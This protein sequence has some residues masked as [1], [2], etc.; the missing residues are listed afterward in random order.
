MKHSA[1][2]M[3][4]PYRKERKNDQFEKQ[5]KTTSNTFCKRV[6]TDRYC[7]TA[8]QRRVHIGRAPER[9]I[10]RE[11]WRDHRGDAR[12]QRTDTRVKSGRQIGLVQVCLAGKWGT[13]AKY[14]GE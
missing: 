7:S 11:I 6:R 8:I 14:C 13:S 1:V 2:S 12:S 9:N 5:P 4:A 10:G 3:I